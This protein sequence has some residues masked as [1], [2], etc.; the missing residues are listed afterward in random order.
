[1][2]RVLV[3]MIVLLGYGAATGA[4]AL[5]DRWVWLFGWGLNSDSDKEQIAPIL[6]TAVAHGLNGVVLSAGLDSL[7]RR[8]PDYFE[9]LSW[10]QDACAQRS[11]E[12][13]PSL[14]SV[15]YG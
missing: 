15:G 2:R 7:Y 13:I 1:M 11:L 14:F 4:E 8:G 3:L 9:R 6:D 5:E 10:L 12:L